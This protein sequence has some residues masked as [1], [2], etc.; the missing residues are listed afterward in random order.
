MVPHL[1]AFISLL[2]ALCSTGLALLVPAIIEIVLAYGTLDGPSWFL[3]VKN[4]FIMSVA[5]LVMVTG[6][7]E[8]VIGLI[9]AFFSEV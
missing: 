2:G 6:T 7:Y 3:I 9:N 5:L 4:V 1:N 8:S